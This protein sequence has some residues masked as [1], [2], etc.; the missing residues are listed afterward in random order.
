M[1]DQEL[2]LLAVQTG[3]K[4]MFEGSHFSI[5]TLREAIK[6]LGTLPDADALKILEPLHCVNWSDMPAALRNSIP[7][8]IGRCLADQWPPPQLFD[9]APVQVVIQSTERVVE[10]ERPRRKLLGVF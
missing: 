4:K 8:L 5:C 6:T 7:A 9:R 1:T 10:V 3:L 2:K